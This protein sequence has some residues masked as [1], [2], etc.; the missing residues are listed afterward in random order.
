MNAP[1]RSSKLTAALDHA[2]RGFRVLPL[3]PN[4]KAPAITDWPNRA[5]TDEAQIFEWWREWPDANI[6][7]TLDTWLVVDVDPKNG[8][9]E[10]ISGLLMLHDESFPPTVGQRTQS[11]GMH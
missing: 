2:R 3:Q 11:G 10:T 8:G 6:G 7:L 9:D 5:T 1:V 4:S